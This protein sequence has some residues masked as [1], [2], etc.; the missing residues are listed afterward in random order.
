MVIFNICALATEKVGEYYVAGGVGPI[1]KIL[2]EVVED[3][4]Q[5]SIYCPY[6]ENLNVEK[7]QSPAELSNFVE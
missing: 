4:F 3:E 1:L 5:C 2:V 6:R 7:W